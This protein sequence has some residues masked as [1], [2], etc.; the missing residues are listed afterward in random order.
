MPTG[1]DAANGVADRHPNVLEKDFVEIHRPQAQ[2][3]QPAPFDTRRFGIEEKHG[4]S[5]VLGY[6]RIGT[7]H[8]QNIVGDLGAGAEHL[9]PVDQPM[10]AVPLRA[11]TKRRRIRTGI[12]FRKRKSETDLA[13]RQL[14]QQCLFLLLR[15][16]M[17]KC[18]GCNDHRCVVDVG[19]RFEAMGDL[20][21]EDDE[22][23]A[24][25]SRSAVGLRNRDAKP[26]Q[27]GQ[28]VHEFDREA[29]LFITFPYV[30]D[31]AFLAHEIPDAI[32]DQLLFLGEAE[33]HSSTP[34]FG[35]LRQ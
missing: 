11:G 15:P 22:V 23:H 7:R 3:L 32:L 5:V 30:L 6:G 25:S 4:Q 14:W 19:P 1:V 27:L 31:R 17:R 16:E 13:A 29:L 8:Q 9:L 10:V 21:E 12:R 20:F 35:L 24:A 26:A 28:L 34:G 33:I 18:I 2:L